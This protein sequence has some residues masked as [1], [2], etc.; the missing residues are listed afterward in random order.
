MTADMKR[1]SDE[2]ST[3]RLR[4]ADKWHFEQEIET[5]QSLDE[6]KKRFRHAHAYE[7]HWARWLFIFSTRVYCVIV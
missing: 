5:A 1:L 6:V 4:D 2:K 7:T 3:S